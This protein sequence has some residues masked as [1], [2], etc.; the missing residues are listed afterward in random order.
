ARRRVHRPRA[1]R[2]AADGYSA[3]ADRR[4]RGAAPYPQ[5]RS[6]CTDHRRR[7]SRR[8]RQRGAGARRRLRRSCGRAVQS[9][10]AAYQG[11]SLSADREKLVRSPPLILIADDNESSREI[12]ARR[13]QAHGYALATAAD[14]EEALTS[15]RALQPDLVLLD[16]M[17]PKLDGLD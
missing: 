8:A 9:M 16:V 11:A 12:L 1:A 15:A 2:P 14:G 4:R 6:G 3:P 17:M 10:R 5:R 7:L 13:L